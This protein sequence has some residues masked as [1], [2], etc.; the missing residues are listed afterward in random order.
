MLLELEV[1]GIFVKIN[2]RN[3]YQILVM[4]HPSFTKISALLINDNHELLIVRG[5]GDSFCKA[6]GGKVEGSE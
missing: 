5:R 6:F 2:Q 1:K 3:N 4:R